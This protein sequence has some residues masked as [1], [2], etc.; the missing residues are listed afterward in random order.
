VKIASELV[1]E[2][3][4]D[5]QGRSYTFADSGEAWVF[6]VVNGRHFAARRVPDDHV[7]VNPNHY[8]IREIDPD[9]G[10]NYIISP[11]LVEYAI[12]RGWYAPK[13]RG[14]FSDFDF[15]ETFQHPSYIMAP[16]NTARHSFGFSVSSGVDI[17]LETDAKRPP[18]SV[19][20]ASPVTFEAIYKTLG[21]HCGDSG[22]F[23]WSITPHSMGGITAGPGDAR[24]NTRICN[25]GNRESIIVDL[26]KNPDDTAV[27]SCFGS[28]CVLQMTPWHLGSRAVPEPF[29]GVY[30]EPG[31]LNELTRRHFNAAREDLTNER[32]EA[33]RL[34]RALVEWCDEDYSARAKIINER[35]K[36]VSEKTKI[37]NDNF[38]SG[39]PRAREEF[40]S[41]D[42]SHAEF[43]L[44]SMRKL[45][46]E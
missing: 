46:G 34:S 13:K 45:I 3:G 41:L 10:E 22:E 29:S 5:A 42:T 12:S 2:Y 32:P 23:G 4:Y 20:P 11:G 33:W 19:R 40:F 6:Q 35:L 26:M 1:T 27:W 16:M 37:S 7:M 28:P 14:D 24:K 43:M 21:S 9:D 36:D 31:S 17:R 30:A 8:S 15:A 39:V 25:G 18:F 38:E 44:G